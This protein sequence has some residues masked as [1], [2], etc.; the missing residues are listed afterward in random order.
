V[1]DVR[2][3]LRDLA[4]RQGATIFLSSH[5][6]GEVAKLASRIG[7]IH[8]GRL[9]E[10]LPAEELERRCRR[11]LVVDAPDRSAAQQAL[12]RA[13]YTVR[14]AQDGALETTDE[15]ALAHPEF[16]AELLVQEGAPPFRLSVEQEDLESHFLHLVTG[17][18][19]P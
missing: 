16:V 1:V 11:R 2:E 4:R 17:G 15:R 13:G 7:I 18:G 8:A 9:V 6:L 10:E 12:T 5:I 14:A 19:L 3:L